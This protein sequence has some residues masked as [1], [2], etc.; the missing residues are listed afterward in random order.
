MSTTAGIVHDAADCSRGDPIIRTAVKATSVRGAGRG[1]EAG[2]S[3]LGWRVSLLE[4][5]ENPTR[6]ISNGERG[7]P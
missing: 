5:R 2:T 1:L 6:D 4:Y 3:P 7:F